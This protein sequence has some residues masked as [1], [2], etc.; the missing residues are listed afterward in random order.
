MPVSEYELEALPELEVGYGAEMEGEG[1]SEQF[2]GALANLARRGAGW[3]T[4]QGSPQRRVALWAA[5]QAL[6]RGLP[7]LGRWVGGR[8]GGTA[9]G[10]TGA[11]VGQRAASWLSGMLPA[12][13]YEGEWESEFEEE[14]SPVRKVYPDALMEHLG[15]A[16]AE[17]QSEA[18]AEALA[19]AMIPLAARAVPG[20]APVILR[21]SPGLVC[22][23]S[24]VVRSLRRSPTTRPLLRTVPSIVRR[25]AASIAQQTA[26]GAPVTPQQAIQTLARQTYRVLRS[27]QQSVR[28]F[29]RSRVLD[30]QFHQGAGAA[31]VCPACQRGRSNCPSCG[32]MR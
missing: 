31:G 29:Q 19:G 2:F 1:E 16:A 25:T 27:P 15:H 4:A 8:I 10:A 30:R 20:A 9:D 23:L 12:R 5:R 22:G 17:T 14:L 13:E 7:A 28:A 26:Q 24:G 11:S 6:N 32:G 21:A 18:E 3:L